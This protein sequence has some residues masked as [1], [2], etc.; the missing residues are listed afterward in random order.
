MFSRLARAAA[1]LF[2]VMTAYWCYVLMV[3]PL[4]EP[5]AHARTR[6]E[7]TPEEI[8]AAKRSGQRNQQ[9]FAKYFRPGDWELNGS[10]KVLESPQLKMLV[11][12]YENLPDGRVKLF[13]CTLIFF[14]NAGK[15]DPVAAAQA[16]IMK[17]P[18]GAILQFDEAFDLKRAK[19]GKLIGGRLNGKITIESGPTAP[20]E[21]PALLIETHEVELVEDRV[22]TPH[23]VRFRMGQSHGSGRQMRINLVKTEDDNQSKGPGARFGQIESFELVRDVRLHVELADTQGAN[24]LW[25]GEA[26]PASQPNKL[27][28]EPPVEISCRGPFRFDF[29][30]SLAT[31]T[32][33][34]DLVRL[35]KNGPGDQLNCELLA[36][37][38]GPREQSTTRRV[39]ARMPAGGAAATTASSTKPPGQFD[40]EPRRVEA[41][42]NPVI[43][44]AP[45][46]GG[47]ARCQRLEYELKTGR[48]VLEGSENVLLH[49]GTHQIRT[50]R[51]DYRPGEAGR[52]GW[53]HVAGPGWLQG[54]L[55]DQPQQKYQAQW[56]EELR[57]R[58]QEQNQVVSIVGAAQVRFADAGALAAD[59]IHLWITEKAISKTPEQANSGRQLVTVNYSPGSIKEPNP[60]QPAV[61]GAPVP[62]STTEIGRVEQKAKKPQR[63]I[64]LDRLMAEGRVAVDSAQLTGGMKR[65]EVWFTHADESGATGTPSSA[66]SQ[67]PFGRR[68]SA[69]RNL[70]DAGSKPQSAF[71]VRGELVRLQL[72]LEKNV[73]RI[74]DVSID[75]GALVTET[76]TAKPNELPLL[77]KGD[78]VQI[79]QADSNEA[80]LNV[81]GQP[82]QVE[83]R[84]LALSGGRINLDRQTNRLWIDGPGTM[85]LPMNRDLQGGA[86]D[87][88]QSM[89]IEWQGGMQFDG[90]SVVYDR[91]VVAR[92]ETQSLK[93]ESLEVVLQQRIDFGNPQQLERNDQRAPGAARQDDTPQLEQV[94]CRG[95]VTL[96]N[97]SFDQDGQLSIDRMQLR[98]VSINQVTGAIEGRGP[99]W[100]TTVRRGAPAGGAF[101]LPGSTPAPPV[102]KPQAA[103]ELSFLYLRFER[104]LGGNINRQELVFSDQV[105]AIYGPVTTWQAELDPDTPADL[106]ERSVLLHC[107]QLT[108]RQM[109]GVVKGANATAELEAL[110]NTL[111]EGQAFTA[112]AHKLSFA[113][114]KDLLVLEGNG[115]MDAQ[116]FR[117]SRP[118]GPTSQA[119]ARRIMF[120]RSTNR[121]EVDDARFLDIGNIGGGGSSKNNGFSGVSDLLGGGNNAARGPAPKDARRTPQGNGTALPA[122][123]R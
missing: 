77:V 84:G 57:M 7:L 91:G 116:L 81:K 59:E 74:S 73:T 30:R 2:V 78:Q 109:P 99:G 89:Q 49:Q 100:I 80:R 62:S 93:T 114:A 61:G 101:A 53:L 104:G 64:L 90:K 58:P 1:S 44:R 17:A 55:E 50:K 32:D 34:V 48:I 9:T 51:F 6:I 18:E 12:S 83:A 38:F 86:L 8:A 106:N 115:S 122:L 4:V 92:G 52:L 26:R 3:V 87:G 85:R 40:L 29:P 45:S 23:P 112:R 43:I 33:S 10:P 108:V 75:G 5:A 25:L 22:F 69:P 15:A 82:A 19:V 76:K 110:G 120:W 63:E 56:N 42:G 102:A 66:A 11:Q 79:A 72:L 36:I 46:Q 117:Q 31:F 67:S 105:R 97:K 14:P 21:N 123:Q 37:Q 24:G 95:G 88:K 35:N 119:A 107:D 60:V 39:P 68:A 113:E 65:L 118:G 20:G 13:P 28:D 111:V 71:D 121:V 27:A 96:Q 98:D 54:S 103:D 47:H 70:S 94:V 16:I 41:V